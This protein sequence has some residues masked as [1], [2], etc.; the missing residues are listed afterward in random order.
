MEHE[1]KIRDRLADLEGALQ[2][3]APAPARLD[4]ARTLFLAGQQSMRKQQRWQTF[5]PL[6]SACLAVICIS[7]GALLARPAKTKIVYVPSGTSVERSTDSR[8]DESK[9][10]EKAPSTGSSDRRPSSSRTQLASANPT[11]ATDAVLQTLV[12][13]RQ[14][15]A[16]MLSDSLTIADTSS[17]EPAVI[18]AINSS[19]WHLMLTDQSPSERFRTLAEPLRQPSIPTIKYWTSLIPTRGS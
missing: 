7:M 18:E 3:I 2:D 8:S 6:S 5:W 9:E 16:Q 1:D 15:Q 17:G 12:D 10:P 4:P 19:D 11:D 13:R 14:R